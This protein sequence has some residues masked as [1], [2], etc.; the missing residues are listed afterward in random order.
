[1]MFAEGTSD[2]ELQP[3]EQKSGGSLLSTL[4]SLPPPELPPWKIG[5][6]LGCDFPQRGDASMRNQRWRQ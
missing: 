6:G 4:A 3:A 1:M 2:G 5:R